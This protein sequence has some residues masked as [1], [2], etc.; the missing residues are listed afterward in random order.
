[1]SGQQ[2]GDREFLNVVAFVDDSRGK[3]RA[4]D[5]GYAYRDGDKMRVKMKAIPTGAW[6]GSLTIE[7]REQRQGGGG[8]RPPAQRAASPAQEDDVPF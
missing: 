6:D 8:Q 7:R 2:Q 1:M 3:K 5:C 4:I